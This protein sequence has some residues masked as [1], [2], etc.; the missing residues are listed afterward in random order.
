LN[1]VPYF[2]KEI[3]ER[4]SVNNIF[5]DKID[6]LEQFN[7]IH[8]GIIKAN[9]KEIAYYTSLKYLENEFPERNINNYSKS[10]SNIY[11]TETTPLN[12]SENFRKRIDKENKLLIVKRPNL[13][14]KFNLVGKWAPIQNNIIKNFINF[15]EKS[16][17]QK[18]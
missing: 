1:L 11:N 5:D 13:L 17:N 6:H 2:L 9:N 18:M 8:K 4:F 3:S 10:Y 12:F 16:N 15:Y 7:Q 14:K